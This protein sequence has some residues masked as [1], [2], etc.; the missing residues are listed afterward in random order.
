MRA[1][2]QFSSKEVKTLLSKGFVSNVHSIKLSRSVRGNL[3][4]QFSEKVNGDLKGMCFGFSRILNSND[5]LTH[6]EDLEGFI[7]PRAGNFVLEF[8]IDDSALF[9][10]L[11]E[12]F[13]GNANAMRQESLAF[14]ELSTARLSD[15]TNI[16]R[17]PRVLKMPKLVAPTVT[18]QST[19]SRVFEAV[20]VERLFLRNLCGEGFIHILDDWR[21]EFIE[22]DS[23]MRVRKLDL[24]TKG[25]D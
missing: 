24:F 4:H 18:T 17:T 16:S 12:M 1:I 23:S 10:D 7:T 15:C 11:A 21:P 6:W 9:L 22:C 2:F 5:L 8:S 14:K 19:P 3:A 25:G 20:V 13:S